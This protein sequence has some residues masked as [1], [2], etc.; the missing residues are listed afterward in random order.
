M[1]T[2]TLKSCNTKFQ[3][4]RKDKKSSYQVKQILAPFYNSIAVI[5]G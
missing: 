1:Q 3:P 2:Q 4:Q 5:L